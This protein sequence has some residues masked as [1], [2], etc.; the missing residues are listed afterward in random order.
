MSI[1]LSFIRGGEKVLEAEKGG[2]MGT[3]GCKP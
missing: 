3:C 1:D 2:K